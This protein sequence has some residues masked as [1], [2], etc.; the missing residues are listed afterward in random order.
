MGITALLTM[1]IIMVLS[2]LQNKGKNDPKGIEITK[3]LFKT[4]P[5]FNIGS[6]VVCLLLAVLY[7][8]FW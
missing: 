7:A 5:L 4:S 2:H 1:A 3:D 8:L 6:M